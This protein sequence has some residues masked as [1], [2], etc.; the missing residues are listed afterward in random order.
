MS[1]P[2]NLRRLDGEYPEP[3]L[4]WDSMLEWEIEGSGKVILTLIDQRPCWSLKTL[5]LF[6]V[7][8]L[9]LHDSFIGT[10]HPQ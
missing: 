1:L 10:K 7:L 3:G 5:N 2:R 6:Q 8:L 9:V 4:G